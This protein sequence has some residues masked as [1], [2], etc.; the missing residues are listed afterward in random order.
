MDLFGAG[1][2]A[3][4][5]AIPSAL[6]ITLQNATPSTLDLFISHLY[7]Y[8]LSWLTNFT[9][10]TTIHTVLYL[11]HYFGLP[12]SDPIWSQ[13][14]IILSSK[15][16]PKNAH[17]RPDVQLLA[18]YLDLFRNFDLPG[19]RTNILGYVI[20]FVC[21]H[22]KK[23]FH[24]SL[25]VPSN[26]G[27]DATQHH[28]HIPEQEHQHYTVALQTI[29][30][31]TTLL[32]PREMI[33]ILNGFKMEFIK[34]KYPDFGIKLVNIVWIFAE[35]WA[36]ETKALKEES[37][38]M[39]LDTFINELDELIRDAVF[40]CTSVQDVVSIQTQLNR[41]PI[42][43]A[44]IVSR[45]N[46]Y[47]TNQLQSLLHYQSMNT[48]SRGNQGFGKGKMKNSRKQP[49]DDFGFGGEEEEEGFNF[50]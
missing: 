7:F 10:I 37:E 23:K 50:S 13:I 24:S 5:R 27:P 30:T 12:Q 22:W 49:A 17:G 41:I 45:L 38:D 26:D 11:A 31:L 48:S 1:H 19:F 39:D 36:D 40:A 6:E 16:F 25:L 4:G 44:F 21:F 9:P 43:S 42:R 28:Y 20:K 32:T 33:T 15:G 2:L 46:K 29:Q 8:P 34:N 18:P 47:T 3:R 14:D 35:R